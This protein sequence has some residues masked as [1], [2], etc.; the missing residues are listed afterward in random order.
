MLL[1]LINLESIGTDLGSVWFTLP[2]VDLCVKVSHST[3]IQDVWD[4][5]RPIDADYLPSSIIQGDQCLDGSASYFFTQTVPMDAKSFCT[6]R[7]ST[8]S[9]PSH[10]D[11]PC[12][13]VEHCWTTLDTTGSALQG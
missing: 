6:W 13:C 8:R 2:E 11:A 7:W 10:H 4:R 12:L 1:L 9:Q 5:V 3:R